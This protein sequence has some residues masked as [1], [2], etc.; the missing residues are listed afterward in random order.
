MLPLI[1]LLIIG[2]D[3]FMNDSSELFILGGF[4]LFITIFSGV[5]AYSLTHNIY[6]EYGTPAGVILIHVVIII[7][8]RRSNNK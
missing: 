1:L 5:L 4:G 3:N 7:F 8:A 6:A 2:A